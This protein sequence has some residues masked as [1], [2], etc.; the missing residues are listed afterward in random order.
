MI[1]GVNEA[2]ILVKY[3]SCDFKHKF[4]GK[5]CNSNQKSSGNKCRCQ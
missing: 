3:I 4:D 1:T 2:K 5:T